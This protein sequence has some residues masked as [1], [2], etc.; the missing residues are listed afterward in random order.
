LETA[1]LKHPVYTKDV[2]TSK[3][4]EGNVLCSGRVFVYVSTGEEKLWILSKLIK[5]RYDKGRP[6]EDLGYRQKE[7]N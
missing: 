6:S 5:I 7:R 3:W 2:F 4:R 1:E